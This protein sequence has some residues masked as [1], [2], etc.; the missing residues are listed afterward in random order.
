MMPGGGRVV[1]ATV[2]TSV[3][4]APSYM[5]LRVERYGTRQYF[6]QFANWKHGANPAVRPSLPLCGS[7]GCITVDFGMEFGIDVYNNTH[8]NYDRYPPFQ[9]CP[10]ETNFL[11]TNESFTWGVSAGQTD[12]KLATDAYQ[13]NWEVADNC[14][15]NAFAIG[16]AK[17]WNIPTNANGFKQILISINAPVG[18]QGLGQIGG[19]V[20]L[21]DDAHCQTI[22]FVGRAQCM[23]DALIVP[24]APYQADRL[25]LR[26]R[27]G[28][29]ASPNKCWTSG[30]SGGTDPS[31]VM[32]HD[33][34]GCY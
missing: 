13:D 30:N 9:N 32:P 15:K 11:A 29:W 19:S 33:Y 7:E 10:D 12:L 8:P 4:W 21:N 27:R 20:T 31:F 24:P 3:S 28:W 22:P 16:L 17:P 2:P 1:A 26:P 23:G 18:K 14:R 6:Y 5:E 34:D 25:T